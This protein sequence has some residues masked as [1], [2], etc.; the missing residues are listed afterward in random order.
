MTPLEG[1]FAGL[2]QAIQGCA[3]G[4]GVEVL[5]PEF[6]RG[7]GNDLVVLQETTFDQ[8]LDRVLADAAVFGRLAESEDIRVG[9]RFPLA[10]NRVVSASRGD[11]G[12]S[13]AFSPSGAKP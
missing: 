10:G 6:P 8:L 11:A 3:D 13:P 9:S 4:C 2:F 5:S 1:Q 7:V 12:L